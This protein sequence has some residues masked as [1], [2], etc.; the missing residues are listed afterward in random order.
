MGIAHG[1]PIHIFVRAFFFLSN[2][3]GYV[4]EP[5]IL[6][7]SEFSFAVMYVVCARCPKVLRSAVE[8]YQE[9]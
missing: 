6:D 2:D 9:I 3:Y 4:Y 8:P 1:N 5:V 7:F